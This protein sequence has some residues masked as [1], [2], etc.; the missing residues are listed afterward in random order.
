MPNASVFAPASAAAARRSPFASRHRTRF[1]LGT[2]ATLACVLCV[3]VPLASRAAQL[4]GM[5]TDESERAWYTAFMA[6]F[7]ARVVPSFHVNP[8]LEAKLSRTWDSMVQRLT[9]GKG[10]RPTPL[11]QYPLLSFVDDRFLVMKVTTARG[12]DS[13]VVRADEADGNA[14]TLS[15]TLTSYLDEVVYASL[16]GI[17]EEERQ[18]IEKYPE[19]EPKLQELAAQNPFLHGIPI[20]VPEM[21]PFKNRMV[22]FS[23]V[24]GRLTREDTASYE[25]QKWSGG[26]T[27][28]VG[29]MRDH[30][31]GVAV[32]AADLVEGDAVVCHYRVIREVAAVKDTFVGEGRRG[33]LLRQPRLGSILQ[34]KGCVDGCEQPANWRVIYPEQAQVQTAGLDP[35]LQRPNLPTAEASGPPPLDDGPALAAPDPLLPPP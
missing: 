8:E 15:S 28:V 6:R 33:M 5:P 4:P 14:P 20:R 13:F 30:Q 7:N 21:G 31:W 1:Q 2:A 17:A 11:D 29:V 27:H 23:G 32:E 34:V 24:A 26:E 22:V 9:G 16:S 25:K 12:K 18:K 35:G 19:Y 3:A 10:V